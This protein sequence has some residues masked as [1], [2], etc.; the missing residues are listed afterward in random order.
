MNIPLEY[1]LEQNLSWWP[2][3]ITEYEDWF[4]LDKSHFKQGFWEE[5]SYGTIKWYLKGV[6]VCT[7]YCNGDVNRMS[8]D[9][10]PKGLVYL[11]ELATQIFFEKLNN[12]K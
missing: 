2:T 12:I 4:I 1:F 11:K 10:T 8:F 6:L 7:S 5:P 9:Y 3:D